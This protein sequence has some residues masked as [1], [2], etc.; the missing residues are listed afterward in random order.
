[1]IVITRL[2]GEA[3]VVD[4]VAITVLEIDGDN[5]VFQIDA[6]FDVDIA[7]VEKVAVE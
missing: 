2:A 3:V 4:D 1:M 5:V 7:P 6:P